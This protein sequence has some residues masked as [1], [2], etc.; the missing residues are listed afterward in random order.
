MFDF[1][2]TTNHPDVLFDP[3]GTP[4]LRVGGAYE[5]LVV[6]QVTIGAGN[7]ERIVTVAPVTGRVSIQ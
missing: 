7:G 6:A 2:T 5:Q 4:V 3:S 1:T